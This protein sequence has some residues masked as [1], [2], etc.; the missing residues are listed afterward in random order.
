MF[1][2]RQAIKGG[3]S[4]GFL[5]EL[6]AIVLLL[7]RINKLFE[8]FKMKFDWIRCFHKLTMNIFGQE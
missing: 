4:V 1:N 3:R 6:T 7:N 2:V 5:F 8:T